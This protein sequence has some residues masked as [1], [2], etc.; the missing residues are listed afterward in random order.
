MR[1]DPFE[2][3]RLDLAMAFL[4]GR[5]LSEGIDITMVA[6]RSEVKEFISPKK[7]AADNPLHT[8]WRYEFLGA[9]LI[10]LLNWQTRH[11][12]QSR[13]ALAKLVIEGYVNDYLLFAGECV[14]YDRFY[15]LPICG[16]I[17]SKSV[18][19]GIAPWTE[20]I[21]LVEYRYLARGHFF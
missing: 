14:Q 2:D 18:E 10:A 17:C 20:G 6:S 19:K 4:R 13:H 12:H 21:F 5:C 7:S 9:D 11:R 16:N 15:L 8:G 3:A 1:P